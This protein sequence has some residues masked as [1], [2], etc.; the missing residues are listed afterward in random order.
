MRKFSILHLSDLHITKSR[1]TYPPILKKLIT[2]V[3]KETKHI[4]SLIL[5]VTGDIIDKAN[6]KEAK[7]IAVSFFSDLQSKLEGKIHRIYITPG[8]HDKNRLG[9]NDMLQKYFSGKQYDELYDEFE[10]GDW[11]NLFSQNF[12]DY[13]SLLG[14]IS[15][16]TGIKINNKLYY[17]DVFKIDDCYVRLN[18]INSSIT[19]FND[20]DYGSLH[21]GKFQI[22]RIEQDFENLKSTVPHIDVSITIMHHP[23]FWL[24]KEEYDSIHYS[25]SSSDSLAT[26]VLLRGH[27]H[28]RSL[29]N[30]YSLYNSFSTLVTGIGASDNDNDHPQRYSIYTFMCDLNLIEIVMKSSS[31]KGFIPDYSAY[32]SEVDESR[33]KIHFPMH[34]HDFISDI[35]LKLPLANGDFQPIFPSKD[36]FE[37]I[38]NFSNKLLDLKERLTNIIF[39]YKQQ[40]VSAVKSCN[41][42]CSEGNEDH[43]LEQWL[44]ESDET[45]DTT[46]ISEA[47]TNHKDIVLEKINGLLYE[48]CSEVTKVFFSGNLK[49]GQQVRVQFRVFNQSSRYHEGLT[50]HSIIG[51]TPN[52]QIAITP[53]PWGKGLIEKSF[54]KKVPLIYSLNKDHIEDRM[55]E[56]T[57]EDYLTYVPEIATNSY[58][59]S[60]SKKAYPAISFGINCNYIQSYNVFETMS[61]LPFKSLVDDFLM[62]IQDSFKFSFASLVK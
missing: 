16:K 32:V 57:W 61:L 58:Y 53:V 45:T 42:P 9:C 28:D 30:Y 41:E 44:N 21:I 46:L 14:E 4:D 12:S 18:S 13:I 34:V 49:D 43:L 40:F 24:C 1:N 35:Y 25:I 19:S 29:E 52:D 59:K 17:C 54:S 60:R 26:D 51:N 48:F 36:V 37:R 27:T 8:N 62:S 31:E 2:D 55:Q 56:T 6:Y 15:D 10:Q 22:D 3:A 38:T 50:N 23:T 11:K 47:L 7:D 5:V 33:K 20:D 39:I